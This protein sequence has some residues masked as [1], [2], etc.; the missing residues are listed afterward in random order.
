MADR[1]EENAIGGVGGSL[2]HDS[3]TRHVTGEARYIDDLAEP[4]RILHL[5]ARPAERA[6]ARLTRLDLD[7]VRSAPGVA[8]VLTAGDIPGVNDIS[9]V[10]A[11]DDPLLCAGEVMFWGQPLF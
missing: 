7:R 3:A 11:G 4:E 8:C 2:A 1:L 5:Y 6:H 10:H 9:P